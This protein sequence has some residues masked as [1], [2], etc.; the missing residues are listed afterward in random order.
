MCP[1]PRA[2][3]GT[4]P[5]RIDKAPGNWLLTHSAAPPG[6][7]NALRRVSPPARFDLAMASVGASISSEHAPS[8]PTWVVRHTHQLVVS[9]L[10]LQEAPMPKYAIA[11]CPRWQFGA[12]VAFAYRSEERRVGKECRSR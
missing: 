3:T 10:V 7:C 11:D 12:W 1:D 4:A 2:R 6:E 9:W 5:F 8:A